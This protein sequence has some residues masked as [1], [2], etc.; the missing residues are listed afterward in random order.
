MFRPKFNKFAAIYYVVG[1]GSK[2]THLRSDPDPNPFQHC[3]GVGPLRQSIS[4]ITIMDITVVKDILDITS[5]CPGHHGLHGFHSF[6]Q[7][8]MPQHVGYIMDIA[9]ITVRP[10]METTDLTTSDSQYRPSRTSQRHHKS[11]YNY[12]IGGR[13]QMIGRSC[14]LLPEREVTR[15]EDERPHLVTSIHAARHSLA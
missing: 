14:P 11:K 15:I 3:N 2:A 8:L 5:I 10:S 9:D 13:G 1:S 6:R 12:G 7:S 4:I